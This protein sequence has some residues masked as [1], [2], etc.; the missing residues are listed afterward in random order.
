MIDHLSTYATDYDAT[1]SFYRSVLPCLGY[2]MTSE[3]VASWD[4]RFPDRRMCSF[5]PG[6][7]PVFWV[8]EVHEPASPRHVAFSAP[9]RSSVKA[10]HRAALAVGARDNGAPGLREIY[11]AG[12]FGAFVL[13]PD[14]NNVEAVCHAP[15]PQAK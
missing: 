5:G 14:G 11:H 10:F 7:K 6:R 8:V 15:A 3:S 13:D 4:E 1:R 2:E 9:D 12:Y